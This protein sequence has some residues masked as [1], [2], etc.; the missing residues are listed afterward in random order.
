MPAL[1]DCR[2]GFNIQST[3]SSLDCSAFNKEHGPSSVIKGTYKCSGN[4]TNPGNIGTAGTAGSGTKKS[5][6]VGTTTAGSA[7]LVCVAGAL[8]VA[9]SML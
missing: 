5:G 7:V 6:A 2:G 3:S 1:K 4:I 9:M 8:A